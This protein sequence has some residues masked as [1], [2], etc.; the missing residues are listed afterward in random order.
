MKLE[1]PAHCGYCDANMIAQSNC[2]GVS[3]PGHVVPVRWQ[4]QILR[5]VWDAGHAAHPD[6]EWLKAELA[7]ARSPEGKA[8]F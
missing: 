1:R 2:E 3:V 4:C 5:A 7:Y 6:V 8:P